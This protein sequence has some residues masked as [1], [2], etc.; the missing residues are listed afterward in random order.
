MS[1]EIYLLR[2]ENELLRTLSQNSMLSTTS[3][4]TISIKS[5]GELLSEYNDSVDDFDRWRAQVNLLTNTYELDD[6]ATKVL[7]VSKM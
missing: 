5:V 6:N 7:L 1:K 2:R 3:R 4:T